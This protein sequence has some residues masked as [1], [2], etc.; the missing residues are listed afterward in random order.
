[1][2]GVCRGCGQIQEVTARTQEE[3]DEFATMNCNCGE[4]EKLR[5]KAQLME[6][7]DDICGTAAIDKGFTPIEPRTI[8]R[9]KEAA[10]L[11][12]ENKIEKATFSIDSTLVVIKRN[13]KKVTCSRRM[14]LELT[15]ESTA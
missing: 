3:A 9:I 7:I 14:S 11:V 4:G 1:M 15:K 2:T 12:F 10:S 8:E 6:S 5:K 13:A